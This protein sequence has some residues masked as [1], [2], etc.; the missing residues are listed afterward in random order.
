MGRLSVQERFDDRFN[1]RL[2]HNYVEWIANR[3]MKSIGIEPMFDVPAKNNPLPWTEHWLNSKGQQNAP[4]ETEIES[5]CHRRNQ[6]RCRSKHLRRIF[7][8]EDAMI[9][10]AEHGWDDLMDKAD[11][12]GNPFAEAMWEMEKKK[13][14]QEQERN[15]VTVLTRVKTLYSLV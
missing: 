14:R 11:Q 13:A 5:L 6:T 15:T 8:D 10:A 7:S 12:P 9:E 3:R 2:L 1:E 4:Q